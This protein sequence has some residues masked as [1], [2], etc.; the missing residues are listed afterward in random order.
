MFTKSTN[1]KLIF[2]GAVFLTIALAIFLV[3]DNSSKSKT[4]PDFDSL[5]YQQK[6]QSFSRIANDDPQEAWIF[7]KNKFTKNNQTIDDVHEFAHIVGNSAFKK[8]GVGG[9]KICDATFSYGCF[10]GV[11]ESMIL[12]LGRSVIPEIEKVCIE[13]FKS[14]SDFL[15]GCIHGTGHGLFGANNN[16]LEQSLEDCKTFQ[17]NNRR[18]C[19]DGVFMEYAEHPELYIGQ[20]EEF[21]NRCSGIDIEYENNCSRYVFSIYANKHSWDIKKIINDCENIAS[22]NVAEECFLSLGYYIVFESKANPEKIIQTCSLTSDN[23]LS[24]CIIGA[25]RQVFSQKYQNFEQ[26][27]QT[28]CDQIRLDETAFQNCVKEIRYP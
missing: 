11:T 8:Y 14:N 27:G 15:S 19:Y 25:V 3:L 17:E 9:I 21:I 12:T 23:W 2:L 6:L 5:T 24:F 7:L 20:E 10:H 22:N 1:I 26:I 18:Y 28:L 4:L 16:K 13:T